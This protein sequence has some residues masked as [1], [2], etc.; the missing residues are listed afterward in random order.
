[1]RISILASRDLFAAP[2]FAERGSMLVAQVGE[3]APQ[4]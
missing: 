1:M 2:L 4:Y 3:P